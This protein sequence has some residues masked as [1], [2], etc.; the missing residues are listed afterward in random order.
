L[1][2]ANLPYLS[3]LSRLFKGEPERTSNAS[4]VGRIGAPTVGGVALFDVLPR[5]PHRARRVLEEHLLLR[6]RHQPEQVARLLPVVG[7]RVMVVAGWLAFDGQRAGGADRG[8]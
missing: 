5:I 6:R 3:L 8:R 7:V 2:C 1:C 4:A